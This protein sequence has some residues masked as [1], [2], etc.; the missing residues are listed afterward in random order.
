M[1]K[2]AFATFSGGPELTPSDALVAKAFP[3]NVQ[4]SA[5]PWDAAANFRDFDAIV[6]RS[7]WNY[8]LKEAQFQ[9]WLSNLQE[10]AIPVFNSA[11]TILWNMNKSYLLELNTRIVPSIIAMRHEYRKVKAFLQSHNSEK[12]VVKPLVS[13]SAH[14]TVLLN[15]ISETAFAEAAGTVEVLVQPFFTEITGG[16]WSLMFFNGIYSH[17]VLKRPKAGDFRVQND[18]GGI[19]EVHAPPN[20]AMQAATAL[21]ATLSPLPLYA[22]VDGLM[23]DDKFYLMELELIEPELFVTRVPESAAR[24]ATALLDRIP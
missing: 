2:I 8:H 20:E 12:A 10:S 17:A 18:F 24:F 14:K 9:S 23:K 1:K 19:A 21:L 6:I 11:E 7:T 3:V 5:V 16:E 4:C 13:A 22:R 15:S